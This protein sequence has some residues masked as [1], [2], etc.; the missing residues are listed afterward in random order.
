MISQ[1]V[2]PQELVLT[3]AD[4]IN[5]QEFKVHLVFCQSSCLIRENIFNLAQVIV[6]T[7]CLYFSIEVFALALRVI[8]KQFSLTKSDNL[9]SH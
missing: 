3:V 9:Q 7:W 8:L 1:N 2:E 5:I 4:S 6:N